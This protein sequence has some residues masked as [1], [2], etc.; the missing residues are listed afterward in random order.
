[1]KAG[2]SFCA[3]FGAWMQTRSASA[4]LQGARFMC[5]HNHC[6]TPLAATSLIPFWLGLG[7]C[8]SHLSESYSA[9]VVKVQICL[10]QANGARQGMGLVG[11]AGS[12]TEL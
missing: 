4:G 3:S 10:P 7:R 5:W 12:V 8:M 6:V 11:L 9:T 2:D 1:V